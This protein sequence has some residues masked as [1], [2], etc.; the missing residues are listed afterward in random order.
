MR[1]QVPQNLDIPDTIFFGMSFLQLLYLGGGI[2]LLF[3]LYL[4]TGSFIITVIIGLPVCG[5]AALLAFFRLNNQPFV[6]ILQS[7]I[8]FSAKKR[9]YVWKKEVIDTSYIQ[10]KSIKKQNT[11]ESSQ[12]ESGK[13]KVKNLDAD[14]IF[15]NHLTGEGREPEITI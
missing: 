6:I 10:R 7:V 4:F 3:I 5:I 9:M 14:L 11:A 13:D 12:E 15:D 2:G 1:F 8:Q